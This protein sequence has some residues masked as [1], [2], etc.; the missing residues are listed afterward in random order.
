M[1]NKEFHKL[2][3]PQKA[4]SGFTLTELLVGLIMG[5]IVI[6]AMGFGLMQVLSM[7]KSETSKSAVRNET[8]RAMEFISDELRRAQSIEVNTDIT[9]LTTADNPSTANVD[10]SIAPDYNLPTGGE[11]VLALQIPEV[12]QRVIYSVAPPQG[13]QKW[14]GP[15]VI[16]RWGPQLN[17]DGS[18]VT[19]ASSAGRVDNPSGWSNLALID[20]VDDIDQSIDCDGNG[21]NETTYQGFYAC[22]LDD[23]GD[24]IT[25]NATDTNGD[26][27]I[28]NNDRETADTNGDGVIVTD[29]NS[30]GVIDNGD[31][32]DVDGIAITAQLY[33]TG[34]IETVSGVANS[35]Y[36]A[37][38]RTVARAR[39]A[40][41]DNSY[42]FTN[43][44]WSFQDL[45]GAFSCKNDGS[46]WVMRTDFGSNSNDPND[47]T[48]WIRDPDRQPQPITVDSSKP[49][50]ITSSPIGQTN[51][52]SR[53]NDYL[54]DPSTGVDADPQTATSATGKNADDSWQTL[55]QYDVKV[56][57][58]ID[59]KDPRTFNG[60]L[61]GDSYDQ[62]EVKTD[63][64][65]VQFLK[66]GS[67]IPNYGGFDA[68]G[69]GVITVSDASNDQ[70]SLGRFLYGKGYAQFVPTTASDGTTITNPDHPEAQFKIIDSSDPS[71]SGYPPDAKFL[72]DDQR[73]IAF[74]VGQTDTQLANGSDNPG[75]DLQDNIFVVTSDVFEKKF[76][77]CAF[78][79]NCASESDLYSE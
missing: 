27:V 62:T 25:E 21:T 53:G 18:Y 63:D 43:Y 67:L 38:T 58:T 45:G 44:I 66:K 33:F 29:F 65:T 72:G 26:G 40:P 76:N 47:T 73:I 57:H 9:Y 41:D 39:T 61:Y 34:G 56:S 15:L 69:D 49:L 52:N 74:E 5:S 37:S 68:D 51:C 59:F 75:F 14:R 22:V 42:N 31:R 79:G 23:D 7:T 35:N 30:D 6:G 71:T 46:E 48:P 12:A 20:G 24:G 54:I 77:S 55:S 3:K 64:P 11:A 2:L 28:D 8:A 32:A 1:N 36:T 50:T 13:Y 19:D 4:N 10:E 16:Y 70:P 17:D 60:D 78:S